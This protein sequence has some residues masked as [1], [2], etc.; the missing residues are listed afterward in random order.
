M[1]TPHPLRTIFHLDLDAFY[2]AVEEIFNPVLK[3][4]PFMVG[5]KANERG[6]VASASYPARKFG[7]RSAMPTGQALR[8]CPKLIVVS[9]RYEAYGE[10]SQKVMSLLREYG[11]TLQQ[12]SVD[13]AFLDLTG[14]STDPK[15]LALEIQKRIKDELQLP[16]SIGVATSKLV[17]KMASGRA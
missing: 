3:G 8:L 10:Y 17:A 1:S 12:I 2:C 4:K 9:G 6:V 7:V 15:T 5:G 16:A 13:E 11:E 14:F